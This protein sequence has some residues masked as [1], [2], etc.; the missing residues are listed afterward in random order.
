MKKLIILFALILSAVSF[1]APPSNIQAVDLG[2]PSGTKWANMN[3]GAKKPADYGDYFAWGEVKPK[4]TYTEDN[5][6]TCGRE[7]DDIAGNAKYDAATANWGGKWKM[8]TIAQMRELKDK[9]TWVLIKLKNSKGVLVKVTGPN[10]NS[11]FLPAAGDRDDSDLWGAGSFG[12]YWSST[13]YEN[14]SDGAYD[15][16]FGSDGQHVSRLR[17]NGLSVRPVLE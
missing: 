6:Q 1:A 5:C 4:K 9:C 13:P 15:L 16:D 7:L 3:V 17:Y 12:F 14:F 2:L 11:I 10:E 8:P